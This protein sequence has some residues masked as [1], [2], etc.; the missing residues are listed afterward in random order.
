MQIYKTSKLS[1][2]LVNNALD[3]LVNQP[4]KTFQTFIEIISVVPNI[5]SGAVN[6]H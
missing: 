1:V 4:I 5:S 3:L 6:K 2:L